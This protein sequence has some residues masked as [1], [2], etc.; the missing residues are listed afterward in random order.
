[1]RISLADT[2]HGLEFE[3][4]D[5]GPGFDPAAVTASG[6]RTMNDRLAALGGSCKVDSSPSRGTTVTGRIGL[7]DQMAGTAGAMPL[8]ARM[9]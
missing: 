9:G 6:L 5:N 1:M 3:V 8:N 7:A 2:G 4:T